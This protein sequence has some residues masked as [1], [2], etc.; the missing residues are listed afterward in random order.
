MGRDGLS[1]KLRGIIGTVLQEKWRKTQL[2]VEE[3]A[4]M[5]GKVSVIQEQ[6]YKAAGHTRTQMVKPGD[7]NQK[8]KVTQ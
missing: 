8:A 7:F 1:H 6:E 4:K 3:L 5:V 2:L